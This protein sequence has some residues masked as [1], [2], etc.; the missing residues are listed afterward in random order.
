[1]IPLGGS[2]W[3]LRGWVEGGGGVMHEPCAYLL[4]AG[5]CSLLYVEIICSSRSSLCRSPQEE[6]CERVQKIAQEN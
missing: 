6:S 4:P 5:L 1:M 3:L 2:F